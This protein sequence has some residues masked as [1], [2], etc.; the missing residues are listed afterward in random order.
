MADKQYLNK[1][2]VEQ[3][4][5][6]ITA[7]DNALSAQIEELSGKIEHNVT[8]NDLSGF[9]N[10]IEDTIVISGDK[11][12]VVPSTDNEH[13]VTPSAVTCKIESTAPFDET[14]VVSNVPVTVIS[15]SSFAFAANV[16]PRFDKSEVSVVPS[17]NVASPDVI[18]ATQVHSPSTP[19]AT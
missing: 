8:W 5:D 15:K 4:W 6:G 18:F 19:E 14:S 13:I 17:A 9:V 16:I 10:K 11:E 1:S 2:G 7:R 3:L 12:V